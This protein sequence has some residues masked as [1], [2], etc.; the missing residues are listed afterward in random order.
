MARKETI[1]EWRVNYRDEHG[2]CD[3]IDF[4][5]TYKEALRILRRDAYEGATDIELCRVEGDQD[6]GVHDIHYATVEDGKLPEFFDYCSIRVNKAHHA[7]VARAHK[8]A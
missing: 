3:N 4:F 7:E 1:Y 8:A 5:D 6:D 2:D